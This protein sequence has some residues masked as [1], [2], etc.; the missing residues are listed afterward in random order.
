MTLKG[1]ALNS[2]FFSRQWGAINGFWAAGWHDQSWTS[3][4][5][6]WLMLWSTQPTALQGPESDRVRGMVRSRG[7]APWGSHL[8]PH[9]LHSP[10]LPP[11][12]RSRAS[13]KLQGLLQ[14]LELDPLLTKGA[15]PQNA[16]LTRFHPPQ[17]VHRKS[18]SL[19]LVLAHCT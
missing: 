17:V 18:S 3:R 1:H 19:L 6:C 7:P 2:D 14:S 10:I 4:R 13:P 9:S 11:W 8:S 5:Q 12:N 15:Q 16:H